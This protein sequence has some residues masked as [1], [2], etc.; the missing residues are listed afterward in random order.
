MKAVAVTGPIAA[1]AAQDVNSNDTEDRGRERIGLLETAVMLPFLRLFTLS[2][3][4]QLLLLIS[5]GGAVERSRR[6]GG[7]IVERGVLE[8]SRAESTR[9]LQHLFSA[10]KRFSIETQST[11]EKQQAKITPTHIAKYISNAFKSPGGTPTPTYGATGTQ[12][13]IV[14]LP[15]KGCHTKTSGQEDFASKGKRLTD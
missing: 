11:T 5:G 1:H 7:R 13:G 15:E 14:R 12:H 8:S 2:G 9:I 3:R 10:W 6:A 4:P